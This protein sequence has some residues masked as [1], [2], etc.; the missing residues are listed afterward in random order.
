[1]NELN[2]T[3]SN[4]NKEEISNRFKWPFRW[5]RNKGRHTSEKLMFKLNRLSTVLKNKEEHS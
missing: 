1:M 2:Q 3:H 5:N 4:D